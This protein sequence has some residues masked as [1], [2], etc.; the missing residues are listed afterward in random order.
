MCISPASVKTRM[1]KKV[2]NQDYNTFLDPKQIAKII[3]TTISSDNEM[4]IPELRLYRM[5][6]K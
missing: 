6:M 4:V 1:G 2:K 3:L 5:T